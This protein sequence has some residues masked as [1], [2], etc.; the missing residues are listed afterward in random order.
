M[1]GEDYDNKCKRE[2]G[3]GNVEIYEDTRC[4]V[5]SKSSPWNNEIYDHWMSNIY[6]EQVNLNLMKTE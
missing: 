6:L 3:R 4:G 1:I 5:Y 2:K